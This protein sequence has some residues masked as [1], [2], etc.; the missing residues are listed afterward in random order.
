MYARLND[1]DRIVLAQVLR[2]EPTIMLASRDGHVIHFKIEEI[3]ILQ[4]VG[5]GV[6]GIK[7]ED[8]DICLGGAVLGRA[9]DQLVTETS[10]GKQMEFTGR[11]E[12]V[13][14]GGK[15][16]EAVKRASFVR[17][18]PAAIELVDWDVLEGKSDD[19]GKS[20]GKNGQKS[21]FD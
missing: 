14:R 19:K 11:Y 6:M 1:G 7:L 8:D 18:V 5:K 10:G 13:S 9:S 21:L 20:N 12:T 3:N 16:F 17:V 4:G 2:D 15:G